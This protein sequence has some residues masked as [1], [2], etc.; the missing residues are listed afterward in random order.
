M[1]KINSTLLMAALVTVVA[2]S[3]VASSVVFVA[4]PADADLGDKIKEKIKK[5][6]DKIKE[7]RGGGGDGPNR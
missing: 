2:T 1:S 3:L 7:R 5:V 6:F 4:G